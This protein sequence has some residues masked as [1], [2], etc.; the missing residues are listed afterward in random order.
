MEEVT[1]TELKTVSVNGTT[2]YYT[3]QGKGEPMVLVHGGLSDYRMWEGQL[4]AFAQQYRVIAYSRRYAYPAK[5]ADDAVGYTVVPHARDLAALIQQLDL[6]PVHLVGHSYGAYTS[7][8]TA[9]EHPELVKSL[10]LGEPPVMPLLTNTEE[11]NALLF[12]LETN[13]ALP[14]AQAFEH[15]NDLE[16]VKIFLDGVMGKSNFYDTMP[17]EVQRQIMENLQ[18][19][20]GIVC[21]KIIFLFWPFLTRPDLQKVEAPTLLI[22]GDSSP[23]FLILI[24]E[25]LEKCLPNKERVILSHA[26][27]EME[28]DNP[29]EFN[30]AVLQFIQKHEN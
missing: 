4:E 19:L 10:C 30:A 20:K 3:E 5:D 27:H 18:E 15:G 22:T 16:A 29:Q 21:P 23:R 24:T 17:P 26:S 28:M 7:L 25:E 12:E 14:A 8:L 6:G 1:S 11:G 13:T 2:L 9:L